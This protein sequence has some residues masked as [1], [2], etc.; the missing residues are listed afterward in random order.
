MLDTS[1]D[2]KKCAGMAHF[3]QIAQ[4]FTIRDNILPYIIEQST[5]QNCSLD[6]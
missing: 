4:Y 3:P 2:Y 5:P 6:S 1:N